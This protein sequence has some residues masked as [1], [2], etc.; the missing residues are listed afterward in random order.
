M[1]RGFGLAAA[2]PFVQERLR[3]RKNP[4]LLL[5]EGFGESRLDTQQ[6]QKQE[7]LCDAKSH[8]H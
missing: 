6:R 8:Y 4:N 3:P 5:T 2:L 1:E 7:E